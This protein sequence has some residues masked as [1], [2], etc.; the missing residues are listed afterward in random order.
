MAAVGGRWWPDRRPPRS[1]AGI[2]VKQGWG[3]RMIPNPPSAAP[4]PA[5]NDRGFW[6]PQ[7]GK[8]H[9]VRG[10]MQY[11]PARAEPPGWQEPRKK[12]QF[13]KATPLAERQQRLDRHASYA[14]VSSLRPTELTS[15][16][17]M[18]RPP[19]KEK[20]DTREEF[21]MPPIPESPQQRRRP[22]AEWNAN[23]NNNNNNN[24]CAPKAAKPKA[25]NSYQQQQLGGKPICE[26]RAPVASA[27]EV[28]LEAKDEA[29]CI[30]S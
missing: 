3:N 25:Y 9:Q 15:G 17:N 12:L 23:N 30:I 16:T 26:N 21:R 4:Q 29:A 7:P 10:R 20:Q 13:P 18:G 11:F 28:R 22:L 27:E 2:P 19:P 14:D 24:A 1:A 8:W 6:A 5:K